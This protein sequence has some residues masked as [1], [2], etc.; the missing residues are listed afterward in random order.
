MTEKIDIILFK[1]GNLEAFERIYRNSWNRVYHFTELFLDDPYEREDMVQ[2]VFMRLWKKRSLIDISRDFDGLLF[3]TTRNIIFDRLRKS[4]RT[5][6]ID[7]VAESAGFIYDYDVESAMDAEF[8]EE[9]IDKLVSMMPDRQREA[10]LLSRKDKLSIKQIA[11]K[12]G[13]TENGVK[14]NIHLALRFIK[15]NLPLLILFLEF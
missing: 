15:S 10:F 13:I 3:I 8:T 4:G 9:Y 12:M 5:E 6:R 7:K 1:D 14:R 2:E 11:Q